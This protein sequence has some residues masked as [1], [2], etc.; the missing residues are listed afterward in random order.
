LLRQRRIA[1]KVD[2]LAPETAGMGEAILVH[3]ADDHD[4]CAEQLARG[5]ARQPDRPRTVDRFNLDLIP[6]DVGD[7]AIRCH[8]ALL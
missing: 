7:A 3:V 1:G 4:R 2:G 5:G 6:C 8:V